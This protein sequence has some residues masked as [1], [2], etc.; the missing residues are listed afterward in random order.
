[1]WAEGDDEN[2]RLCQELGDKDSKLKH[3]HRKIARLEERFLEGEKCYD[4]TIA[5]LEEM[6]NKET[7]KYIEQHNAEIAQIEETMLEKEKFYSEIIESQELHRLR[8]I[9]GEQGGDNEQEPVVAG[10]AI[11]EQKTHANV[12]EFN[13]YLATMKKD[14]EKSNSNQDVTFFWMIFELA[15]SAACS[16]FGSIFRGL[17]MIPMI[18]LHAAGAAHSFD[19]MNVKNVNKGMGHAFIAAIN[20]WWFFS[21]SIESDLFVMYIKSIVALFYAW[22]M[23]D[24]AAN[25]LAAVS[26]QYQTVAGPEDNETQETEQNLIVKLQKDSEGLLGFWFN[27]EMQIVGVV[28]DSDAEVQ[29]LRDGDEIVR[30]NGNSVD[31]LTFEFVRGVFA[32][33][34]GTIVMEVKRSVRM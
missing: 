8:Q 3:C 12:D 31:G 18:M 7:V 1:L 25:V 23:R 13:E 11:G 26:D 2:M 10:N 33:L 20:I 27:S 15:F 14:Q 22:E 28:V 24:D 19:N 6:H 34:C 16:Q 17:L 21:S 4:R 5:R 32:G 30:V 29:G 9:A